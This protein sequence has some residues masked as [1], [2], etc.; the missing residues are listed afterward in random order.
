MKARRGDLTLEHLKEV[1]SYC[2]L[3]GKFIWLISTRGRQQ[4]GDIAGSVY[5]HG[6][7]YIKIDKVPHRASRLAWFYV[8]G[9]WPAGQID[10][11][12]L[13]RADD[14]FSN[15][16]DSTP[17]QNRRNTRG[18]AGSATGIKGVYRARRHFRASIFVQGE[19]IHLG[20]FDDVEAAKHARKLA[21]IRYYGEF[22]RAHLE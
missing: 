9:E 22:G 19:I 5:P 17:S 18:D 8:Y 1:L 16:R 2:K 12:N 3:T 7:R 13:R 14:R 15:L 10:H 21:E 11:K 6:Y 4:A 20:M